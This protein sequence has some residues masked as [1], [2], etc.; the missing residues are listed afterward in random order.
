MPLLCRIEKNFKLWW[1]GK[2]LK[3]LFK[4]FFKNIEVQNFLALHVGGGGVKIRGGPMMV[5]QIPVR[6]WEHSRSP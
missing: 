4:K 2:F 5:Q 3:E 1:Y 6:T